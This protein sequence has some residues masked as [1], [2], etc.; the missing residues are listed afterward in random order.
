MMHCLYLSPG[1]PEIFPETLRIRMQCDGGGKQRGV[2]LHD[3][4]YLVR[5]FFLIAVESNHRSWE[6]TSL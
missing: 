1:L 2:D 3:F 4:A 5:I 6:Y